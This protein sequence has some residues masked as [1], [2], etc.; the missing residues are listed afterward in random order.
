MRLAGRN[1]F[2]A[3]DNVPERRS[4]DRTLNEFS[5]S[6]FGNRRSARRL[7]IPMRGFETVGFSMKK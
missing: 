6:R 3:S 7:M 5:L 2:P 1:V 4:P